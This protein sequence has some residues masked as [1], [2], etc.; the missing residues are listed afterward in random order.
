M[1]AWPS[2]T[3]QGRRCRFP[4]AGSTGFG[5]L[6]KSVSAVASTPGSP[7][8]EARGAVVAR[9][10]AERRRRASR[11]ARARSSVGCGAGRPRASAVSGGS[12]AGTGVLASS[13]SSA[14]VPAQEAERAAS[15]VVDRRVVRAWATSAAA[16]RPARIPVRV[17]VAVI[18]ASR[19]RRST[20]NTTGRGSFGKTSEPASSTP[21]PPARRRF[22]TPVLRQPRPQPSRI[23]LAREVDPPYGRGAAR[24]GREP[25][26]RERR[27]GRRARGDDLSPAELPHAVRMTEI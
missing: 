6:G 8:A 1:N 16:R 10:R 27:A 22:A 25:L 24:A 26:E 13:S 17:I 7:V 4:S 20:A 2:W 18:S 14:P 21:S 15:R 3:A 12:A 11:S 9:R 5:S 23:G 19:T